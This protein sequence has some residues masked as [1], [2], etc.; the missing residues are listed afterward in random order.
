[1]KVYGYA[2][3]S[4]GKQELSIPA[5]VARI[6]QHF[7]VMQEQDD[8]LEWGGVIEEQGVSAYKKSLTEREGGRLLYLTAQPGDV[9]VWTKMDRAF[10]SVTDG[11]KTLQL[12]R[13]KDVRVVSLDLNID[14]SSAIGDF[15]FKLFCLLGELGSGLTAERTR[16]SMRHSQ[17]TGIIRGERGT[18]AGYAPQPTG[19]MNGK[20]KPEYVAMPDHSARG[21]IR[22]IFKEYTSGTSLRQIGRRL[23]AQGAK[24]SGKF[25]YGFGANGDTEWLAYAMHCMFLEWPVCWF[26]KAYRQYRREN[27]HKFPRSRAGMLQSLAFCKSLTQEGVDLTIHRKGYPHIPSR[28]Y[29]RST[30]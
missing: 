22:E 26:P 13:A 2:R 28:A 11:A 29:L 15:T 14:F 8:N 25:R 3:V 6:E 9:V 21:V 7:K 16:D 30:G 1:M 23:E 4:T 19:K 10:R 20:G 17:I 24:R 5:Q 27:E 18:P 12:F